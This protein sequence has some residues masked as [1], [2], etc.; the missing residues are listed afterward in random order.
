MFVGICTN[1]IWVGKEEWSGEWYEWYSYVWACTAIG[2]YGYPLKESSRML[3]LPA[4]NTILAGS[5]RDV[6]RKMNG[7]EHWKILGPF[8]F[9]D[10]FY[11][12]C[13][14]RFFMNSCTLRQ[15]NQLIRQCIPEKSRVLFHGR[16][17]A[18]ESEL[19]LRKH[20]RL[21]EMASTARRP[22]R[23]SSCEIDVDS[24]STD[25]SMAELSDSRIIHSGLTGCKGHRHSGSTRTSSAS[26]WRISRSCPWWRQFFY[27][28]P[29]RAAL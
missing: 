9:G 11:G 19:Y 5:R 23:K 27:S 2:P 17:P 7:L 21:F 8:W 29:G 28:E 10:Y 4:V 26:R 14:I 18:G 22:W 13:H 24:P 1:N 6:C 20:S 16:K 25:I 15:S 12:I 3:I